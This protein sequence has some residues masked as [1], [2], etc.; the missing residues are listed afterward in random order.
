MQKRLGRHGVSTAAAAVAALAVV[1]A[2]SYTAIAMLLPTMLSTAYS[3]TGKFSQAEH[4]I[5]VRLSTVYH[6]PPTLVVSNDGTTPVRITKVYVGQNPQQANIVIN[7]GE[8]YALPIAVGQGQRVAVE[9]EGWGVVV[10]Q[11]VGN[12]GGVGSGPPVGDDVDIPRARCRLRPVD[13]CILL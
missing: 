3:A 12:V 8:K 13:Q 5:A 1:T 11:T 10:L 7:P 9:V 4:D 6:V 2:V